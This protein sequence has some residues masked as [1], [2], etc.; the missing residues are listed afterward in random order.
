[1]MREAHPQTLYQAA[2][3]YEFVGGAAILQLLS[4]AGDY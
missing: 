4:A 2:F 3:N 1:M